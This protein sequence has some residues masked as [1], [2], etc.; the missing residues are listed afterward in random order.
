MDSFN[1]IIFFK[2]K[3]KKTKKQKK[4]QLYSLGMIVI[5]VFITQVLVY[6]AHQTFT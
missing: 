4:T 5:D 3:K 2:K 6:L 1:Y